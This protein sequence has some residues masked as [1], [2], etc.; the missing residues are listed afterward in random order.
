MDYMASI[1]E[2]NLPDTLTLYAQTQPRARNLAFANK[3]AS[4]NHLQNKALYEEK[5]TTF[6][7]PFFPHASNMASPSLLDVIE[8]VQI[9]CKMFTLKLS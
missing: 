5:G 8:Q 3:I 9:S 6:C 7:T 4:F 2:T 1:L